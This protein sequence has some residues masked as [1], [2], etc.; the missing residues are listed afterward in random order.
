M[1]NALD[2]MG[3]SQRATVPLLKDRHDVILHGG[4]ILQYLLERLHSP[5]IAATLS[6]GLDGYALHLLKTISL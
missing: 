5:R 6:D 3:D 4:V 2:G 1:L